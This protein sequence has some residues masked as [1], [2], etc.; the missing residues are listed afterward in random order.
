M[1]TQLMPALARAL[2]QTLG[3]Q[4]LRALMQT[5]GNCN[6]PLQHRGPVN[7]TPNTPTSTGGG[8]YNSNYWDWSDYNNIINN[9][10]GD[11][12][13]NDIAFNS[14]NDNRDFRTID[15]STRLGDTFV[16]FVN[17]P[18]G[19]R[20]EK[21]DRGEDGVGTPG[22]DGEPGE[23]GEPGPPGLSIV[24][25]PGPPGSPGEDGKDGRDGLQGPAGP[26][27]PPGPIIFVDL[28]ER[29]RTRTV[30]VVTGA[31]LV[32]NNKEILSGVEVT[33]VEDEI[34]VEPIYEEV[35]EVVAID[36]KTETIRVLA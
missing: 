18:P 32:W 1:L 31:E 5:L 34:N 13:F 29:L 36:L 19:Q 9:Y 14:Y 6:Q 4:D 33:C 21:G 11:N 26:P 8:T 25:P 28:D 16:T 2:G 3:D 17:N 22:R 24:G 20:G 15:L 12:V 10:G 27:G 7:I 23:R 30:K 35:W